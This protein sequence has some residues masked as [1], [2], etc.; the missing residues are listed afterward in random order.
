MKKEKKK[1][2]ARKFTSKQAV[3][4]IGIILLVLMYI[5]TLITAIAD[6]T[7]SA[8]WFRIS[9]FATLAVPLVIWIYTWMYARLT[10]KHAVGDPDN[11]AV[12][13]EGTSADSSGPLQQAK[14][15][16]ACSAAEE[17]DRDI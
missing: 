12:L 6:T 9:L 3:A 14:E 1:A 4:I 7:A 5:I 8:K 2:S 11:A 16:R 15:N 17:R 13:P 10:G